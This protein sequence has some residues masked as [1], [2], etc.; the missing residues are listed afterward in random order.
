MSKG[1]GAAA[2]SAAADRF[3]TLLAG[4]D[5][6]RAPGLAERVE[7]AGNRGELLRRGIVGE[8]DLVDVGWLQAGLRAAAG[9]VRIEVRDRLGVALRSGTGFSVAPGLLLT[10]HHVLPSHSDAEA[11][12][13]IVG[14][15]RDAQ[16]VEHPGQAVALDPDTLY[17]AHRELDY[18]LVALGSSEDID[19]SALPVLTPDI[20]FEPQAQRQLTTIQH[21]KGQH[22]QLAVGDMR[23]VGAV[24]SFLHYT[25]DTEVGS[26]GSPVMDQGWS[27]VALHH[28]GVPKRDAERNILTL[29]GQLWRRSMGYDAIHY[30]ANEGVMMRSIW[31][32]LRQRVDHLSEGAQAQVGALIEAWE[33]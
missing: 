23:L 13:A 4:L 22:K 11:A 12:V 8:R 14:H 10:N 27:V 29:G 9:V 2:A 32:H 5:D 28:M 16:L 1:L 6:Q 19:S 18:A 30:V 25:V 3:E 33:G 24:E 17:M 15:E 26:S 21:P 31:N 20:Y 7:L